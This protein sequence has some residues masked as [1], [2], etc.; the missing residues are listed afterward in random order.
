MHCRVSIKFLHTAA[1]DGEDLPTDPARGGRAQ[2]QRRIGD[3]LR[4]AQSLDGRVHQHGFQDA[5]V[6]HRF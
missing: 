5:V 2:E 3:V 4:F 6:Q 1:R